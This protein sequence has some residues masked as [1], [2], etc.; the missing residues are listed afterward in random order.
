MPGNGADRDGTAN[1]QTGVAIVKLCEHLQLIVTAEGIENAEQLELLL[2]HFPVYL[3]GYFISKP[4][5]FGDLEAA[6]QTIEVNAGMACSIG[7]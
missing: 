6:L 5:P 3:Q 7:M 4:L 2:D 1:L